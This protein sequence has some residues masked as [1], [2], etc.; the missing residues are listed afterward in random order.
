MYAAEVSTF[1]FKWQHTFS[2]QTEK[3]SMYIVIP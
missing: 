1:P 3:L 2:K